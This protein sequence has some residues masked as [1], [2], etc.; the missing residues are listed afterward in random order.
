[1][2]NPAV[3]RPAVARTPAKRKSRAR[4]RA[5]L[6]PPPPPAPVVIAHCPYCA[7]V[8]DPAPTVSRRCDRCR[9]RIMVK[10][11]D[12]QAVYLTEAAVQ[13]FDSERR[14]IANAGR[15]TRERE[16]WL[17]L[18]ATAGAPAGRQ[19]QL[20]AARLSEEVVAAS[21]SLYLTTVD[22]AFRTAKRDRDWDGAAR[23]RRDQAMA[24]YRLAGSPVPP[25]ADIVTTYREGVA[26]ELRGVAEISRD[27]EL[28]SARCR[29]ACR[30]DDGRILRITSEL[31]TLRLPHGECP[32]GLCRCHWDLAARDRRTIRRYLQRRPGTAS[33]VTAVAVAVTPTEAAPTA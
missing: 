27:A 1:V 30:A 31:R 7:L 24:L 8:L 12:G 16:R 15:L 20:A 10:R 11:V 13:V 5:A 25:P 26:A 28:V 23:I 33:R 19:A 18:A 17:R 4:S 21:R 14:R 22:R 32:K 29:D 2:P 9:Q 6:P 3:A